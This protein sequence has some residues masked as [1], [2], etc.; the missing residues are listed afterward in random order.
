MPGRGPSPTCLNCGTPLA[1][2]YCS[3]CG[4]RALAAYPPL[5][6]VASEAW[7]ELSGYDG[8]F[9]RTF[10]ALL[11][12]PGQLTVDTL[13]GRRARYIAPV[14]LYLVASVFYFLCAAAVPNLRTP[15]PATMPR[16]DINI[17]IDASGRSNLT[18]E[19]REQALAGLARAPWWAK[20]ILQPVVLDPVGFQQRFLATL[21]RVLFTLVPVFA[22]ILALFYRRR[23]FTQHLIF[24]LHVHTTVFMVLAVRELSQLAASLGVLRVFEVGAVIVIAAYALLAFRR[25]YREGW[26][27]VLLKSLGVG[28]VYCLAGVAALF[29]TTAWAAMRA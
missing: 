16:S 12:R 17:T 26:P 27:R 15:P 19:E 22:A 7:Q 8:R 2:D 24:A 20:A 11:A 23:P 9:L 21:P 4:Q 14:R 13:E 3:R 18:P 10:R 5:R 1:G 25:V 28:V 29:L 6:E